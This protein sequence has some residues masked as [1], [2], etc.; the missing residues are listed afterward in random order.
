MTDWNSAGGMMPPN[1]KF[2]GANMHPM[3]PMFMHGAPNG[4]PASIPGFSAGLYFVELIHCTITY[5]SKYFAN[6]LVM[7]K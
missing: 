2:D 4:Y 7:Q 6:F 3:A 5:A 1:A